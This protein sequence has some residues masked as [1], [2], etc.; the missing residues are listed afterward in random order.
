MSDT[1]LLLR[2]EPPGRLDVFTG[3][4]PRRQWTSEQKA[5]VIVRSAMNAARR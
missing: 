1:E 3:S 2:P 4:G 5:R